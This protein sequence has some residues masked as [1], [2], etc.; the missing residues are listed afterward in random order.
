MFF[1]TF[2]TDMVKLAVSEQVALVMTNI[3]SPD[4]SSS[5]HRAGGPSC[6]IW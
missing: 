4:F 1:A 3:A 5:F 2:G 6:N